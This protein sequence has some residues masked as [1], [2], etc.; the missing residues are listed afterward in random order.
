MKWMPIDNAYY[1]ESVDDDSQ[2]FDV[3]LTLKELKLIQNYLTKGKPLNDPS[4]KECLALVLKI[5]NEMVEESGIGNL[6]IEVAN[7]MID[8]YGIE[9][10]IDPY[11]Q[12]TGIFLTSNG[13][14]ELKDCEFNFPRDMVQGGMWDKNGNLIRGF[15]SIDNLNKI[16][17]ASKYQSSNVKSIQLKKDGNMARLML[18]I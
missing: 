12:N 3:T 6:D 5:L 9:V 14:I 8:N 18:N 7:W 11:G 13:M 2:R 4:N 17:K 15:I 10:D 16:L 1:K